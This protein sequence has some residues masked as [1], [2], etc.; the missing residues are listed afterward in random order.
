MIYV[1]CKETLYNLKNFQ[2]HLSHKR[3]VKFGI[4]NVTYSLLQIWNL[5]P[6][7]FLTVPSFAIFRQDISNGKVKDHLVGHA[8]RAFNK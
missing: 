7:Y 6:A 3:T 8:K 5:L 4:E 2:I 1:L